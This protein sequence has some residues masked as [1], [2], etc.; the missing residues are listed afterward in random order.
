MVCLE[1]I[2]AIA[3][4]STNYD[5]EARKDKILKDLTKI[6]LITVCTRLGLNCTGSA[7]ELS[8]RIFKNLSDLASLK[9]NFTEQL[10]DD[11]GGDSGP[12]SLESTNDKN[13]QHLTPPIYHSPS[14]QDVF[15]PLL[16]T[17]KS[18][19]KRERG[20]CLFVKGPFFNYEVAYGK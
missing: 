17:T 8:E 5:I 20:E 16:Q 2:V 19:Q 1:K 4:A 12:F 13:K 14:P 9:N 3:P 15:A 11:E 7:K 18:K 6:E 10:T